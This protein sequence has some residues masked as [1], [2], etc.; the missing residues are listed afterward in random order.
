MGK[1]LLVKD[2]YR[3]ELA[4]LPENCSVGGNQEKSLEILGLTN[5]QDTTC[6][7]FLLV[8]KW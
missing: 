5:V 8:N 7:Y 6:L 4:N 1:I 2:E 3:K